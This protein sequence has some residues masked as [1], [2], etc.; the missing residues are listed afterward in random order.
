MVAQQGNILKYAI[1]I[2]MH[3]DSITSVPIASFV[4]AQQTSMDLDI[5]ISRHEGRLSIVLYQY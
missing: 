1:S 3:Q 5:I 2:L 4:L